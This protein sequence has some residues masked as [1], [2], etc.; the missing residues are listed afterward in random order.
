MKLID[1]AGGSAKLFGFGCSDT[2]IRTL[3]VGFCIIIAKKEVEKVRFL[4]E[5]Y[6]RSNDSTAT[7][8]SDNSCVIV[9]N[10]NEEHVGPKL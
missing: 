8:P 4:I 10:E 6:R 5:M 9:D 7:V 3:Y 2:G 1:K